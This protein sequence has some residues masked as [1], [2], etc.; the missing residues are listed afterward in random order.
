MN[1]FF[2]VDSQG[3]STSGK[4]MANLQIYKNPTSNE[5]NAFLK[6]HHL[7]KD[8]FYFDDFTAVA[9]RY[10]KLN[11]KYLGRTIIFVITNIIHTSKN[12][13]VEDR[14]ETHIFILGEQQLFWFIKGKNS[15]LDTLLLEKHSKEIDSLQSILIYAGLASYSNFTKELTQQKKRIDK[16]NKQANTSTSKSTLLEVTETERNLV[17]LEH[18]I[19]TQEEAFQL[20]LQNEE[21]IEKLDNEPLIHDIKWYNRQVKKLVHMYRDLFDAVSSLFSDIISNH[22][23][24]L[25][26]FLSSFSLI[27]AASSLIAE[28]WGMNTGGLPLEYNDYG[29]YIMIFIALIAGLSMYFFLKNKKFFDD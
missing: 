6:N 13:D 21:F 9:S 20:L 17:L 23:N 15:N 24:E 11:N 28:L 26:K 3:L 4:N 27:L 14:L 8:V 22:L 5:E 7:P 19:N 25:M 29:T 12:S 10:E 1:Q 18:V 16:L 2:R